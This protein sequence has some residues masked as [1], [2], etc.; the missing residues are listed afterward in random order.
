MQHDTLFK[1]FSKRTHGQPVPALLALVLIVI[2]VAAQA[3]VFLTGGNIANII[4]QAAIPAIIVVGLSFVIIMG[5]IDLSVEGMMALGSMSAALLVANDR[6]GLDIGFWSLPLVMLIG[7][8]MGL[9]S[10]LV[11][12]RLRIPSF[13]ATI[14]IASVA[15]GIALILFGTSAKPQIV[16]QTFIDLTQGTFLGITKVSWLALLI[17]VAGLFA[18]RY[19]R[20]GR[21]SYVI[22][23]SEEIAKLS[24][25]DVRKYRTIAFAISGMCSALAG[26]LTAS[27]TS[28]GSTAPGDGLLFLT[29]ASVVIGGTVLTGGRGGVLHSVIGALIMGVIVTGMVLVGVSGL[30][31]QIIQGVVLIV[32]VTAVAWKLRRPMRVVL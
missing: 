18:Q 24:G 31:Q 13:L 22:G 19:T 3:P 29:I 11:I 32:A 23:G 30:Y 1:R 21:Y 27:R 9:I 10:G 26:A 8:L 12:T 16:D 5:S 2:V 20:F 17:V 6:N 7:G 28:I 14:A 15:G 4:D 25:I